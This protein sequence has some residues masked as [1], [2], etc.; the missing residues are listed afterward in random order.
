MHFQHLDVE[1]LAQGCRHLL[2]HHSQQV[3]AQAHVAGLDDAGMARRRPDL[4]VA[5]LVDAG[6]ADHV[7]EARLGGKLDQRQRRLR[8][9]EVDDAVDMG[10][11]RDGVIGDGNVQPPDAGK[12]A[13]VGADM[14]R[15]LRLQPA[16]HFGS[17]RLVDDAR[18]HPAHAARGSGDC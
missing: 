4:R 12:L 6:G 7:H 2:H 3:D 14:G 15:A 17:G 10:E 8:H 1:V 18:Q 11:Q 5:G 16:R 13:H 9:G